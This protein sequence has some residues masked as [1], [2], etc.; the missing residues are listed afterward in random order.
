MIR[1]SSVWMAV[2][3]IGMVVPSFAQTVR[4]D[5]GTVLEPPRQI[6]ALPAPGG[7]PIVVPPAPQAA[8]FDRSVQLTP[9][10][11]R[12]QGNTLVSEAE[13]QQVVVAFVGR[14]TD[15]GGL[16][17]A[18]AAVR[19]HYRDR[20]YILTEAYLPQ[21]QF[22]ATGGTV[23]IQVLEARIGKVSAR[24]E[25]QGPSQSLVDAIVRANLKTGEPVTEAAL[26]R[27]ILLLRDLRGFVATA[28]V[29]PGGNTGEADVVVVVTPAGRPYG[30]LLGVDN[31]GPRAAGQV[32]AYA[33]L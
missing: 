1:T 8:S 27:P 12:F 7:A 2:S 6:P 23:T 31:H 32:R 14:R 17:E 19:K 15:M 5:A 24:V 18:T 22:P 13:L 11:F 26:E 3:A 21:Q 4:P 10:A 20:G 16:V 25:G 9:A 30:A 28:E 29:L 33:E